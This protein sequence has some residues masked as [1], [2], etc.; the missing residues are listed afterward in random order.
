[1]KQIAVL[2]LLCI[3]LL[4]G[5]A[6][7]RY[8]MIDSNEAKLVESSNSVRPKWI[9][10]FT[11]F[12]TSTE[13][14]FVGICSNIR[15]REVENGKKAAIADSLKQAV[16]FVELKSRFK[17][18]K[19]ERVNSMEIVYSSRARL[20]QPEKSEIYTEK[21]QVPNG[22]K[23]LDVYALTVF[24]MADL[25][26]ERERIEKF[27]QIKD[28]RQIIVEPQILRP[29]D[30]FNDKGDDDLLRQS[31]LLTI[32]QILFGSS[33]TVTDGRKDI[34]QEHERRE[35]I[36]SQIEIENRE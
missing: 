5:C 25:L 6:P 21:W 11:A 3:I 9:D 36:R 30:E 32:L 35:R 7:L 14:Y 15:P 8:K 29:T 28:A 13:K 24:R 4:E 27:P 17:C 26:K 23:Y 2:T 12:D 18:L 1:M 16:C 31:A 22:R 19:K 34:I 10:S 33:P 20:N